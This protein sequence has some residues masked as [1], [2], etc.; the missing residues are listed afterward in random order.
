MIINLYSWD[1]IEKLDPK[2][3]Q[4]TKDS[5]IILYDDKDTE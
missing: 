5:A 2:A 3:E 1:D 4:Y